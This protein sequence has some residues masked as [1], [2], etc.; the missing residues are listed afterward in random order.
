MKEEVN[1]EKGNPISQLKIREEKSGET[2]KVV[3]D[4]VVFI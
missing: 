2:R 4:C 1:S 3:K